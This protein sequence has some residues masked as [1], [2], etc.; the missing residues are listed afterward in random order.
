MAGDLA[1]SGVDALI[2]A[3]PVNLRYLTGFT[4]SNGLALIVAG[5]Q[6]GADGHVFFTD[7]RYTTQSAEQVA[8]ALAREIVTGNLLDAAVR[9]LTASAGTL[10]FDDAGTSVADH[11]RLR[12][13]LGEGWQLRACGGAVERLRA[14]KD[15]GEVQ[16]MRAAAQLAD[17]ALRSAAGRRPG[18]PLR[19]RRGGRAGAAHAPPRRLGAEL[20]LDRRRGRARRAAACRAA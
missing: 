10:G 2:V 8:P 16:H 14:V 5:E 18:G 13:A 17:E 15:E 12:A 9:A 20:P 1:A 7:F 19:A 11:E 6:P 3:T 4:G